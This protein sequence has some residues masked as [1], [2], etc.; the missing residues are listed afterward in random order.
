[1]PALLKWCFLSC[2]P[3]ATGKVSKEDKWTAGISK[4]NLE[5]QKKMKPKK[6]WKYHLDYIAVHLY[7][8]QF[9]PSTFQRFFESGF[10]T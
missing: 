2:Y 6:D 3:I 10:A 5:I 4:W 7:E 1:M 9:Q 8:A